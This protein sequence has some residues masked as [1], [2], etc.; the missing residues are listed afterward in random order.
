VNFHFHSIFFLSYSI[1]KN[2][3][4]VRQKETLPTFIIWR[5]YGNIS[6]IFHLSAMEIFLTFFILRHFSHMSSMEI[7]FKF[8]SSWKH[9]P[10]FHL[11]DMKTLITFHICQLC[12]NIFHIYHLSAMET[13]LICRHWKHF[14]LSYLPSIETFLTFLISQFMETFRLFSWKHCSHFLI[15]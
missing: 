2:F 7:C 11:S 4:S 1:L 12:G 8:L 6:S 10:Y 15:C 9:F 3:S 14:S 5:F 13:F